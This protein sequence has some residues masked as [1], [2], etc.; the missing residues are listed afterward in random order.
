MYENCPQQF[1]K[2]TS[3]HRRGHFPLRRPGTADSSASH[4][5]IGKHHIVKHLHNV[6][7][8]LA[9]GKFPLPHGGVECSPSSSG[10]FPRRRR[11][12]VSTRSIDRFRD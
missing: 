7:V 3:A 9:H 11:A 4:D 6:D 8:H 2:N 1:H 10:D 5:F 12:K